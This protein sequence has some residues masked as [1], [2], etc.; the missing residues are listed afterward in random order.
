MFGSSLPPVVCRRVRFLF[1]LLLSISVWWCPTHIV[2]SIV[3]IR[4]ME[5]TA[6]QI[7]AC[8]KM[9]RLNKTDMVVAFY[10]LFQLLLID[11]GNTT[12]RMLLVTCVWRTP[13]SLPCSLKRTCTRV[14]LGRSVRLC[15]SICC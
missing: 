7:C 9:T 13:S 8:E 3:K 12:L 2:L 5:K 1:A 10:Q 11:H 4:S 6:N 15:C 14:H